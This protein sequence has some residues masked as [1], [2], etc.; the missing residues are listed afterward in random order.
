MGWLSPTIRDATSTN[1]CL[2]LGSGLKDNFFQ[3]SEV[4]L[5]RIFGLMKM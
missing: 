3:E 5:G 2:D 4:P 1:S